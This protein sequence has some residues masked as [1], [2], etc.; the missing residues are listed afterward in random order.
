MD[1]SE[2]PDPYQAKSVTVAMSHAKIIIRALEHRRLE[3]FI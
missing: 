3:M 1:A 2:E